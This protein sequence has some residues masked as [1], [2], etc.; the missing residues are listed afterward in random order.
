MKL[1]LGHTKTNTRFFQAHVSAALKILEG[2]RNWHL[3]SEDVNTCRVVTYL[4]NYVGSAEKAGQQAWKSEVTLQVF[5]VYLGNRLAFRQN[6]VWT[7][8][9]WFLK[10]HSAENSVAFSR[11]ENLFP[12]KLAVCKNKVGELVCLSFRCAKSN[13]MCLGG[14]GLALDV[15]KAR[16]AQGECTKFSSPFPPRQNT[17]SPYVLAMMFIRTQVTWEIHERS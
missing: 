17:F 7:E 4:G 15:G 13:C 3:S 12:S 10:V 9:D 1:F 5:L 11:A 16:L 2:N 8:D 14:Q 6:R